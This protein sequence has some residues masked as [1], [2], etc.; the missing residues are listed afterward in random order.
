MKNPISGFA[1]DAFKSDKK[2][3]LAFTSGKIIA[4]GFKSM[5]DITKVVG[6]RYPQAK[7]IKIVN[8]TATVTMRTKK[9]ITA[10][11]GVVYEPE[12]FPACVW[13]QG[14]KCVVYYATGKLILTGC[15]SYKELY[16]LFIDFRKSINSDVANEKSS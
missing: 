15:K 13:H 5:K 16:Q 8:M 7:M 10:C 14:K 11:P 1:A 2:C 4:T 3:L 12:I 6:E 9:N